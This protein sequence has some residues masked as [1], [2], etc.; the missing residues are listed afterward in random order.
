MAGNVWEWCEDDWHGGY[1]DGIPKDGSAWVEQTRGSGRVYRG[2]GWING[3]TNSRVAYRNG[4]YPS[5]RYN[6]LGFRVVLCH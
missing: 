6:G 1:K 4:N 5:N 2:G 3:A